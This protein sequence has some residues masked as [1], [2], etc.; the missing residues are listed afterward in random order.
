MIRSRPYRTM[1]L[2]G[3]TTGLASGLFRGFLRSN[4][5]TI[6]IFRPSLYPFR[7]IQRQTDA[8]ILR[9]VRV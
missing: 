7:L 5:A 6:K 9:E 4:E 2:V 1:N 8:S 3:A